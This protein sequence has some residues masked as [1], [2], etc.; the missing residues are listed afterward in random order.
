MPLKA[1]NSARTIQICNQTFYIK[2]V[3]FHMGDFLSFA[4]EAHTPKLD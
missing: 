3:Y 4:L 1:K 2:F